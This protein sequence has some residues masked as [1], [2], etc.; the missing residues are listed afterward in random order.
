MLF[1]KL[2][3]KSIVVD[4]KFRKFRKMLNVVHICYVRSIRLAQSVW[5]IFVF[6]KCCT[7]CILYRVYSIPIGMGNIVEKPSKAHIVQGSSCIR[8][9]KVYPTYSYI[10]L[11]RQQIHTTKPFF[12]CRQVLYE[13]VQSNRSTP[14]TYR[15][16]SVT[17]HIKHT[18]Y[19]NNIF[20]LGHN[21]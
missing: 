7:Q 11:H 21:I 2:A 1:I 4:V 16:L 14:C 6:Y 17:I 3:A 15:H 20:S 19:K 13:L 12:Y 5:Q 9:G 18:R 10:Y 8:E